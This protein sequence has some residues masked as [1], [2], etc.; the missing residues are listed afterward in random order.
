VL[1]KR[2]DALSKGF[3]RRLML[4]MA[5]LTPHPLLLMDEPFD[6]FD[7]RQTREI[8]NVL[9]EVAAGGRTFVLAI[10][11]LSDAERVCDRFVLLAGGRVRG[12]GTLDQLCKRT[13][14]TDAGL[15][16]VFLALT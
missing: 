12:T 4:A 15:E 16:D 9:R 2:V 6:G 1:R 5:L 7:L 14:K 11:Q 8:M 3:C 13:G 10:H